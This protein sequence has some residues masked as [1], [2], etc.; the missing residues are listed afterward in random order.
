MGW[1]DGA[2]QRR[3]RGRRGPDGSTAATCASGRTSHAS[4]GR[5]SRAAARVPS[6]VD[7]RTERGDGPGGR[8]RPRAGSAP[9]AAGRSTPSRA[10][11]RSRAGRAAVPDT[12]TRRP[13]VET[14]PCAGTSGT[15][16]PG[17]AG[18]TAPRGG[19]P[20]NGRLRVG[21]GQRRVDVPERLGEAAGVDVRRAPPGRSAAPVEHVGA[22]AR[23]ARASGGTRKSMVAVGDLEVLPRRGVPFGVV[24]L[25]Q[26]LGR[27]AVQRRTRSSRRRSPRPRRRSSAR[28]RRTATTR[29]ARVAGEQHPAHPHPVDAAGSGTG[30][31]TSTRSRRAGRR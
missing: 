10:S 5:A 25:Q 2:A 14:S 26:L 8:R 18:G 4:P 29:C 30:R 28:A 23:P 31:P 12:R 20:A 24:A 1:R 22:G 15:S 27:P 13:T 16:T 19:R 9:S 3:R 7:A 6:A 11:T 17:P 21:R